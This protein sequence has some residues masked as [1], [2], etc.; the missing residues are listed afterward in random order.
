M[1]RTANMLPASR[2]DALIE[3]LW[4]LEDLLQVATLVRMTQSS[5]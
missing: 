4:A 2:I 5:C 1:G 3:Q